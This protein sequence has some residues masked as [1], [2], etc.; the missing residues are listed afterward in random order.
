MDA[1]RACAFLQGRLGDV[2]FLRT[3][4]DIGQQ[5]EARTYLGFKLA[6]AGRGLEAV[7]LPLGGRPWREDIYRC[8]LAKNELNRLKYRNRPSVV[9]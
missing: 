8:E 7:T 9:K 5:T 4:D 3:A 6:L 1:H 2:E